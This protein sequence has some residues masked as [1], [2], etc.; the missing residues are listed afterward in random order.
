M[1]RQFVRLEQAPQ[2]L[3]KRRRLQPLLLNLPGF[4][5][6]LVLVYRRQGHPE[7]CAS[8]STRAGR[9]R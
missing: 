2:G 9:S 7:E 1:M 6:S 4:H 3:E 8:T 5:G